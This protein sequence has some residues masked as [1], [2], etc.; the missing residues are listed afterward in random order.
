M[1]NRIHLL[2]PLLAN[3]IAAGEV[4]ERPASVIKELLEN[5][6]DAGARHITIHVERGGVQLLRVRDDG[7]GIHKDDLPL[8][9]SRHA[10][11]KIHNLN[12]LEQ[13]SSLGFRGEALASIAAVS[14]LTLSSHY[15][16]AETGW[17]IQIEGTGEAD[18]Q[19]VA[20]PQGTTIEIRDLF[21]NTPGRRKFLRTEKTEFSHIEEVV[22]RIAL[23]CLQAGIVLKHNQRTI[24]DLPAAMTQQEHEQRVAKI[25][26]ESFIEQALAIETEAAGLKLQGWIAKP[27]F[28][29][30][31]PDL[32]Y[33]YV[34][35]RMVRDKVISHAIRQA[36][37]D[38]MYGDRY[39]AYVLFLTLSAT[40]VDVNVHPTKHEVRF[41]ESRLVHDF[42]FKGLHQVLA[43]TRPG[44]APEPTEQIKQNSLPIKQYT[45]SQSSH[46]WQQP[47]LPMQIREQLPLYEAL[48]A[49]PPAV[50]T[51]EPQGSLLAA[52]IL[53]Q[54][55]SKITPATSSYND[56]PPLGYAL[57]QLQGIYILA[58]NKQGLVIVDMHAAHERILYEQLKAAYLGGQL[59]S[60]GLLLPLSLNLT[61]KEA[62]YAEQYQPLFQQLGF[63]MERL[64]PTGC[65]IR[66]VPVLLKDVNVIQLV[67]DV[68]AD[69]MAQET[70]NRI[71]E[72]LEAILATVAC[73]SSAQAHRKLTIAEM[74]ALLRDMEKTDRSGQ[75]NHGRPTFRQFSMQELDK[76]FLRGR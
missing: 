22:K 11:S 34:N 54:S 27:V 29:R 71:Q 72:T 8:A 35:G 4:I 53:S 36:Y 32:Q 20:H 68:I 57:G 18:L 55:D 15:Q 58:E 46:Q 5:S 65:V 38:V 16:G 28:S 61:E 1:T 75:C 3:Q 76:F 62:D 45:H 24:L 12:E 64:G 40:E 44:A 10:T 25:C 31:Q 59:K 33:F 2:D 47:P 50:S 42:I 56:S 23:G 67:R 13:V 69:L 39:P 41:R 63:T 21:F 49:K 70:S 17:Q 30:S 37:H 9:L 74:N 19:P 52:T 14:R 66:E 26:G 6:L 60:Q 43:H 48:Y 7:S 51:P 73:R